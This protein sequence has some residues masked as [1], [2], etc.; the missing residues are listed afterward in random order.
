MVINQQDSKGEGERTC[1]LL[2]VKQCY[3]EGRC[4]RHCHKPGERELTCWDLFRLR[5]L[6]VVCVS[7]SAPCVP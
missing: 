3:H 7:L 6:F 2:V 1:M 4:K 5:E